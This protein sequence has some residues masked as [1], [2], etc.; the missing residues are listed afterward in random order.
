MRRLVVAFI[1]VPLGILLVV[2][3]VAAD[4]SPGG[5]NF[6]SS[7]TTCSTTGRQVCSDLFLSVFANEDGS[8]GDACLE[9]FTYTI[10]SNGR[11][12]VISDEFGC[13]PSGL[14]IGVDLSASLPATDIALESCNR[15]TC[16]VSRTVTVS[17]DGSPNG[18]IS[19]ST[20]RSTTKSGGCT[21]RTT[22]NEQFAEIAGTITIDG[23]TVDSTG[24]VDVITQTE[25]TH[26][27]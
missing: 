21:T 11:G 20:T 17:G 12:N 8:P 1:T 24:S 14:V 2:G 9:V 19:A 23:T 26:C 5:T 22:I 10:S 25:T 18:P 13:G 27:K 3:P 7:A 15:R 6:S 16:S 4:T